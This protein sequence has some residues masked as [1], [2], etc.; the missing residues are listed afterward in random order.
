M[1]RITQYLPD[2][3]LFSVA[4]LDEALFAFDGHDLD[5]AVGL[6]S[7]QIRHFDPTPACGSTK[8]RWAKL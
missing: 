8:T 5:P 3:E 2:D 1:N 7:H 4:D 6:Q